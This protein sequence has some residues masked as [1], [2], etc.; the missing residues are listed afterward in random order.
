ML[1]STTSIQYLNQLI[2]PEHIRE[3]CY[4]IL[5]SGLKHMKS[6]GARIRSHSSDTDYNLALKDRVYA[7][8]KNNDF[9]GAWKH[10]RLNENRAKVRYMNVRKGPHLLR[11]DF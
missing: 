8:A 5:A 4:T 3:A 6:P 9:I 2:M 1:Y 11:I 7:C 10:M